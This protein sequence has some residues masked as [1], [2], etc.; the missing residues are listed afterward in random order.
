MSRWNYK[1]NNASNLP[2]RHSRGIVGM[3]ASANGIAV[4]TGID[5]YIKFWDRLGESESSQYSLS[6]IGSSDPDIISISDDGHVLVLL[7]DA[8]LQS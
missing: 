4:T 7:D 2:S 8:A 6:E 3:A 5:G 1:T